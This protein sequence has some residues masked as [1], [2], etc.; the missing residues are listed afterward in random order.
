MSDFPSVEMER[1]LNR[2]I[3]CDGF[4]QRGYRHGHADA[5]H[6][7]AVFGRFDEYFGGDHDGGYHM[8]RVHD[9]GHRN[10]GRYVDGCALAVGYWPRDRGG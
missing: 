8:L 6:G 7:G 4:G 2:S 3:S 5:E 9:V 1:A 10:A